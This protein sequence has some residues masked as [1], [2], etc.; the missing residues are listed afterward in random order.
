VGAGN[1]TPRPKFIAVYTGTAKAA[2]VFFAQTDLPMLAD[3]QSASSVS[4]I[5]W[6]K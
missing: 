6:L 4:R 1:S 3:A 5:I 2:P